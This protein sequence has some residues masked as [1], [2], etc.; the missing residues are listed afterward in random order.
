MRGGVQVRLHTFVAD[1]QWETVETRW[2]SPL[3]WRRQGVRV[4][5]PVPLR[6]KGLGVTCESEEGWLNIGGAGA[7][8]LYAVQARGRRGETVRVEI[9]E[10]ITEQPSP[11]P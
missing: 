10:P 7:V 1:D 4:S 8:L 2:G 6:V 3:R 5:P 9:G 11:K